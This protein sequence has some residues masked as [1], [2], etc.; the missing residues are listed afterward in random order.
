[1]QHFRL[2]SAK[3][4]Y[5]FS[6][7]ISLL[8]YYH[9]CVIIAAIDSYQIQLAG[10]A[11][12]IMSAQV[13][14]ACLGRPFNLGMLYDCR[15]EKIIPGMRLWSA[16]KLK[17]VSE[18][19]QPSC[20]SIITTEDTFKSKSS[21]LSLD[22]NLELSFL[23][24]LVKVE[25][26]AKFLH[27][28]K[29][30]EK[31][32]RVTLQFTFTTRY[33]KLTKDLLGEIQY[34][35]V[36]DA[37]HVVTGITYGAD[38]FLVFDRTISEGEKVNKVSDNMEASIKTLLGKACAGFDYSKIDKAET[39]KFHCNFHGDFIPQSIPTT[40][41]EAI[42]FCK[43]LPKLFLNT[44][45]KPKIAYLI[46]LSELA[47]VHPIPS[48][49]T[50]KVKE[51]MEHFDRTEMRASDLM[52]HDVCHK[53][54]D[55][56]NQL[57]KFMKLISNF[58]E[59]FVEKLSQVLP[60]IRSA[61]YA[62]EGSN[63]TELISSVNESPFNPKETENYL[64]DKDDEIK[65]L[66]EQLKNM[67]KYSRLQ[68]DFPDADCLLTTLKCNDEFEHVF[69]FAF[70]VTSETCAYLKNLERY[71]QTGITK[72]ADEKEWFHK[73]EKLT[74]EAN[75]FMGLTS[76]AKKIAFVVTSSNR[77]SSGADPSIIIYTNGVPMLLEPPGTPQADKVTFDSVTLSWTAPKHCP[78]S[79]YYVF[80]RSVN[81][82]EYK[83]VTSLGTLTTLHIKGL[84]HGGKYEFK[85]QAT[86]TFGFPIESDTAI[87]QTTVYYDIVLVGKTGQ[88][89]S[90]LGNKLLDLE[91]THSSDIHL[92]DKKQ[93]VQAD[94]P[95]VAES[96]EKML[97]VTGKCKIMSNENTKIRVLDVPG[98]SDSG[99][100]Q[101]ATGQ[102]ISVYKGNLQI[103]R[104]LV[105]EQIQSQL[106]VRR[107]VY[108]LPVRGPLEKADGM[109]QEELKMLNH[110]FGKD[111]F[112]C[113]VVVATNP[114]KK[115]YQALGFDDDDHEESKKVFHLALKMAIGRK[116]IAF[117][118]IVYIGLHDSPEETLTKVKKALLKESILPLQF[119]DDVCALCSFKILYA[120]ENNERICVV[121]ADGNRIPYEQSKC[122][123]KFVPKYSNAAKFV[124]GVAHVATL[125]I[126]LLVEHFANIDTWPGF[127]N[128]DEIC[129]SCDKSPG[130]EGCK[131]VGQKIT[132][133][134]KNTIKVDHT[135]KL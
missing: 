128:S 52:K 12:I 8:V 47:A 105:R 92:F 120:D 42:E 49:L 20:K 21:S 100:L 2:F 32:S 78:V 22:A 60:K 38:A 102:K 34:P 61:G 68:F 17:S 27:D 108:F 56:K 37:T 127:T 36:Q 113:M 107:I 94:D 135:N 132:I 66:A 55:V 65:Q 9:S 19:G 71:I 6:I 131:Q 14:I 109:M 30:S 110:Y 48:D 70:N 130:S 13:K 80:Y 46:P 122:H 1:M 95:K 57:F 93:F 69:C 77:E 15:T 59:K 124:G 106:K 129:I 33:E 26:A 119:S 79:S 28:K 82:S 87:I 112:D 117:P 114:P 121:D 98:F 11:T 118:P 5:K 99:T 90:T 35:H 96:R 111:V 83:I 97:S 67:G 76:I 40:F 91:N 116:D 75:R 62:A 104:W 10:I 50:F 126:G 63:L 39:D 125:G 25:G 41:D 43:E 44:E 101:K 74:S 58:K 54:V 133:E 73:P 84:F 31:Q 3:S 88:G 53:F 7:N 72:P 45:S 85:V 16:E 18:T 64:K 29:S 134:K 103:I 24:G 51:I 123:P 86:T 89:K 23:S 4:Y 81:E 115:R